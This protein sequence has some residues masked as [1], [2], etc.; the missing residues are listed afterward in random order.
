MRSI[1]GLTTEIFPD[2][3]FFEDRVRH[4]GMT[5]NEKAVH[6]HYYLLFQTEGLEISVFRPDSYPSLAL[7]PLAAGAQTSLRKEILPI[8]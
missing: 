3:E 6:I 8:A 1:I 4:P 7:N 5:A 2:D